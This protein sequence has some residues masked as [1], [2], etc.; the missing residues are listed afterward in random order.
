VWTSGE[1][2]SE[3]GCATLTDLLA[4]GDVEVVERG[5]WGRYNAILRWTIPERQPQFFLAE[6]SDGEST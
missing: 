4:L 2:C 3:D 5:Q 6:L 1:P